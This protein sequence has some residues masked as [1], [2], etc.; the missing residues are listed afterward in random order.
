MEFSIQGT[1]GQI[2]GENIEVDGAPA[3]GRVSGVGFEIVWQDR[4]LGRGEDRIEAEGAFV[5]DV[6][7]ALT[8]RVRFYQGESG[9]GEGRF[10]C[11]ENGHMITKMEEALHWDEHRTRDRERR[12]VEGLL[13][14]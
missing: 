2:V 13:E 8:P 3:G 1:A 9:G 11:R 4:P 7:L 12:R 10:R 5:A 14:T 6:L